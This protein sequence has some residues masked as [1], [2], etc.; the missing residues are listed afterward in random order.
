MRQKVFN[1]A[2][3][4][5]CCATASAFAQCSG[6]CSD[7]NCGCCDCN[8][9]CLI[10]SSGGC[11]GVSPIVLD[12]SG[13]GFKLTGAEDGVDFDFFGTGKKLR[14]SWTA[15]GSGNA[16]LVLDRNH[17]GVIDNGTEMFGN[18]APQPKSATPNGFL[19]LAVFDLPENGGN[20][21]G[22][23]DAKD[24]IYSSLR[25][26]IDKNHN[27]ISEPDEL[28]T[29]PE[30][31]VVSI[32]LSYALSQQVDA[33]GNVFRYKSTLVGATH[34][35]DR[36]VYDVFLVKGQPPKQATKPESGAVDPF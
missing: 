18:I 15:P 29:L 34:S 36:V 20:G 4:F 6:G 5:C 14:I 26:W 33:F 23:I 27:G 10:D 21:D 13:H 24:S 17:N 3:A 9:N 16:W 30:L 22:I 19:A 7:A 1:L 32:D 11:C 28:F 8:G 35:I 31:D 25:L 2:M 12:V